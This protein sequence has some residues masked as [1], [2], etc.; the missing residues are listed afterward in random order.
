MLGFLW[1]QF[2][3]IKADVASLESAMLL[4]IYIDIKYIFYDYDDAKNFVDNNIV[5]LKNAGNI[6]T[7]VDSEE[8]E[9]NP[10]LPTDLIFTYTKRDFLSC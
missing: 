1:L 8:V 2:T 7:T 3:R 6:T 9:T 4:V 5:V 10:P